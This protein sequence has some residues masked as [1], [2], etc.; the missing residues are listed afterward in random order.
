MTSTND[1]CLSPDE[2]E[3]LRMFRA[4]DDTVKALLIGAMRRAAAGANW[5]DAL[6]DTIAGMALPPDQA[7]WLLDVAL[8]A[9]EP[10]A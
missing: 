4:A 5:S 7:A 2:A 10:T 6:R 9:A 3:A 8:R 1:A